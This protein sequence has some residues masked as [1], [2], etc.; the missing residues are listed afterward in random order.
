MISGRHIEGRDLMRGQG[1]DVVSI[2]RQGNADQ[3]SA[4]AVYVDGA[5][6]ARIDGLCGQEGR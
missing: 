2:D 3:K 6:L 4:F 5:G 1:H